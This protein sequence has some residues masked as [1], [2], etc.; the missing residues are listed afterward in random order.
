M[1]EDIDA[2]RAR[3]GPQRRGSIRDTAPS[4]SSRSISPACFEDREVQHP[5]RRKDDLWRSIVRAVTD[6]RNVFDE[7]IQRRMLEIAGD[8][9]AIGEL[10]H[11]LIAPNFAADGSPMLTSQAAAV[12]AAYRH[13]VSI[14]DV[15]DPGRR[16]EVMQNLT[17]ATAT[18]DP[19]VILQML[20]SS[21]VGGAG[22]A[23][24]A[25]SAEI[26][27]GIAAGFDD[28]KVAQLLATTL[29][30]EGQ[31][32]DR[33]AGVFDTIAQDEPRKRRVL[34]MTK[35][36][37]SETSFGKSNQFQTLWTSMEELLLS[38]NEKPFVS[39][40]YKAGLDQ[41]G[42]R[43]EAMSTR[44]ARRAH[45]AHRDPRTGQRPAALGHS[46]RRSAEARARTR[47][48]RPS[49][50]ATSPRSAKTCCTPG[51]TRQP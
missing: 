40:Q 15:M 1:A 25:T 49:S 36:L 7:A 3:G 41:I 47:S 34:T 46:A 5:A 28:F 16:T 10:A 13:L 2:V 43:A 38:Y 11:D 35:T 42:G 23:A 33:L 17:A 31:A 12:I 51:T 29:A 30:I 19:R 50:R 26:R 6:R 32:S 22:A 14:V 18:L 21:D 37:L 20:G 4:R 44:R 39:A 24:G 45:A 9:V 8:T 27:S 48:G